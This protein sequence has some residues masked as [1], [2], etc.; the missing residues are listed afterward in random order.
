GRRVYE[1]LDLGYGP[2]RMVLATVAGDPD[3][4][5]EALRRLGVVRVAT[6]YP[7]VASAYLEDTGRQAEIV[8][9]KGS[10]ELAPLTGMVEAIVAGVRAHGDA[11]LDRY[12]ERFDATGGAPLRVSPSELDA[13]AAALR[14]DVRAGLEVAMANVAAVAGASLG[15]DAELRLPQGQRIRVRELPVRRA[16]IYVPGGR[17]PYPSTVVMG[18]VTARVAVVEEICV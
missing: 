12:V 9:V 1:L 10:V 7:R 6:K 2:C 14:S 4:A 18:A 15:D 17:A 8:E 5:A 3:P 11:A 13:A 16:G